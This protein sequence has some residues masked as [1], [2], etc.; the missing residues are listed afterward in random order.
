MP[1]AVSD[2]SILYFVLTWQVKRSRKIIA[3][4]P[5]IAQLNEVGLLTVSDTCLKYTEI[6]SSLNK[7]KEKWFPL[8]IV[9]S[10]VLDANTCRAEYYNKKIEPD[11]TDSYSSFTH[12]ATD[13]QTDRFVLETRVTVRA[14]SI[15]LL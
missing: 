1:K 3:T 15:F 14:V 2:A 5:C 6:Y 13:H 10:G 11:C 12:E 7:E 8:T 4:D 9:G